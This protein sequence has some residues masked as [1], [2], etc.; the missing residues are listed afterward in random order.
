M[1]L[2]FKLSFTMAY[3]ATYKLFGKLN[4]AI[5]SLFFL[6]HFGVYVAG[7]L[8]RAKRVGRSP[9]AFCRRR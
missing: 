9:R 1:L 3:T 4:I 5:L 7:L 8:K 6:G 2:L